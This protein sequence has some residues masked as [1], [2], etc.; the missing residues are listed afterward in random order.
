M[1][2]TAR[3][4][5]IQRKTKET[6]VALT[7]GLDGG[8]RQIQTGIGFFDHLL[9][10][11]AHHGGMG[12]ELTARG[13]RHVDDHHTVEDVGIVMG[14][15]LDKALGDKRGIERFGFASVP[16][17]DVLTRVSIDL[18]GRSAL[19]V[20]VRFAPGPIGT[21]DTQLVREFLEALVSHGRFNCHIEQV[22]GR[23]NHHMAESIF[24]ALGRSVRMAVAVTSQDV[25]ST[26]GML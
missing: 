16:M 22:R 24:K 1:P 4:A 26:K 19:A 10:Q 7:F 20:D 6:D 15:A 17:D 23:N 12:L 5:T 8:R 2:P 21:F 14:Q 25:P 18:S 9:E 3:T 13:D 11:F